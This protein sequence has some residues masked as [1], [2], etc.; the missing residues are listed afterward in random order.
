MP[1]DLSDEERKKLQTLR[2]YAQ[3]EVDFLRGKVWSVFSWANT[4]LFGGIAGLVVLREKISSAA[5]GTQPVKVTL[6]IAIVTLAGYA[7][8][9]LYVTNR[10][11]DT[12]I[13]RVRKLD[14][15]LGLYEPADLLPPDNRSERIRK[16]WHFHSHSVV[17]GVLALVAVILLWL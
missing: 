7:A 16:V 13:Y 2:D 15:L 4:L 12:E 14:T 9:W 6:T 10:K 3:K 5:V 17:V 8:G 1:Q 11:Q